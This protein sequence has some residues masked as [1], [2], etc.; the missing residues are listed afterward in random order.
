MIIKDL[1]ISTP[2]KVSLKI[3]N[4]RKVIILFVL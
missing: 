4:V 3:A 2:D 1:A